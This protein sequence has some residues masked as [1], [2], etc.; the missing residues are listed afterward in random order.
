MR[1]LEDQSRWINVCSGGVRRVS[2]GIE[3]LRIGQVS[4]EWV[5]ADESSN[6]RIIPSLVLVVQ[7]CR[8]ANRFARELAQD[9]AL[10]LGCPV[11]LPIGLVSVCEDD[12]CV[13][14]GHHPR[15]SQCISMPVV[16]RTSVID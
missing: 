1:I 7:T 5:L 15:A 8:L 13:A 16:D 10:A 3:A 11:I 12:C 4:R 14:I 6:R 2:V 9:C